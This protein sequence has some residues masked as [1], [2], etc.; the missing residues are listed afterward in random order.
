MMRQRQ[1]AKVMYPSGCDL[2]FIKPRIINLQGFVTNSEYQLLVVLKYV[3]YPLGLY[4]C[5]EAYSHLV[6]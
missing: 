5:N 3:A 6:L 4:V 1:L 2:S